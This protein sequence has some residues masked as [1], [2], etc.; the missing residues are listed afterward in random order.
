MT[1]V[2]RGMTA[3]L[4]NVRVSV[5]ADANWSGPVTFSHLQIASLLQHKYQTQHVSC[6]HLSYVKNQINSEGTRRGSSFLPLR[7][8]AL[9]SKVQ[10][11]CPSF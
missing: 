3:S 2:M 6:Q 5:L 11:F 1:D 7:K 9:I 10:E 8:E 4:I